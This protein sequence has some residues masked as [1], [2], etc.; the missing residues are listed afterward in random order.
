MPMGMDFLVKALLDS[1]DDETKA[2]I[3]AVPKN[4]ATVSEKL[5]SM[6]GRLGRLEDQKLCGRLE[7]IEVCLVKIQG[8]L[9]AVLDNQ[10]RIEGKLDGHTMRLQSLQSDRP[11]YTPDHGEGEVITGNGANG[12]ESASALTI[13]EV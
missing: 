4:V 1:L 7:V 5:V 13:T 3:A 8:A 2:A 6:D 9:L 10:A 12:I 11:S